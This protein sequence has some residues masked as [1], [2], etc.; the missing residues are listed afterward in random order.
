MSLMKICSVPI[1]EEPSADRAF[2]YTVR[3]SPLP[4]DR[5][6][7]GDLAGGGVDLELVGGVRRTGQ[8]ADQAVGDG[9]VAGVGVRKRWP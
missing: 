9:V 8:A 1:F 6:G 5:A 4:V 3:A 2:T 7:H